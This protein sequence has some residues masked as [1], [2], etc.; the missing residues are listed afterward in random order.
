M[1]AMQFTSA[2]KRKAMGN[3]IA[4]HGNTEESLQTGE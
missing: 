4:G 2:V 3:L 1:L